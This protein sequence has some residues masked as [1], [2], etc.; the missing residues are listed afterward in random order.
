MD[1]PISLL[2]TI[3][4]VLGLLLVI[5]ELLA[6][7]TCEPNS[8]SEYVYFKIRDGCCFVCCCC[9]GDRTIDPII[10]IV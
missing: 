3:S 2:Y 7:S 4:V 6:T 10:V 5:S 8:I 1:S 9:W